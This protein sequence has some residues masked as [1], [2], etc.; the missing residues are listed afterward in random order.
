M[1]GL[2]VGGIEMREMV[3][4][5]LLSLITQTCVCSTRRGGTL[6]PGE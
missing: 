2:G 4:G 3:G 1:G 6:A 5:G